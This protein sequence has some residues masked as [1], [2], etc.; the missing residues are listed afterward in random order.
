MENCLT[1]GPPTL[2]V[3]S[4]KSRAIKKT[5]TSEADNM[6]LR[7]RRRQIISWQEGRTNG[8]AGRSLVTSI[9]RTLHPNARLVQHVGVDSSA[10]RAWFWVASVTARS[11]AR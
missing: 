1:S 3:V 7:G 4:G 8:E 6:P 11:P 10:L 9:Q 2:E 5:R